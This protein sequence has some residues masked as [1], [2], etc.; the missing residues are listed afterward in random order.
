MHMAGSYNNRA[1]RH[2]ME[3]TGWQN[4]Q[5]INNYFGYLIRGSIT[6]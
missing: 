1:S 4:N 2:A 3:I 5:M 6:Q